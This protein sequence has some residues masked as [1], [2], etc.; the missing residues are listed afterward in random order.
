MYQRL[1]PMPMGVRRRIRHRRVAGVMR[2]PVMLVVHVRVVVIQHFVPVLVLVALAHVQPH[3]DGH[4]PGRDDE[5]R[6]RPLAKNQ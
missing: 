5:H 4:E 6:R 2:M 1:V 3:S